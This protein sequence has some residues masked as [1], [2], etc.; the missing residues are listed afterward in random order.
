[1]TL[2]ACIAANYSYIVHNARRVPALLARSCASLLSSWR[3]REGVTLDQERRVKAVI[4]IDHCK[5]PHG[6]SSEVDFCVPEF[7]FSVSC[8]REILSPNKSVL[9]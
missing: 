2:Q 3:M 5:L 9:I 4:S 8:D 7:D 6:R 1:M